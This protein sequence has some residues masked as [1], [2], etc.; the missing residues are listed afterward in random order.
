VS[1]GADIAKHVAYFLPD[2]FIAELPSLIGKTIPTQT[3]NTSHGWVVT[4]E[5]VMLS[6]EETKMREEKALKALARHDV[7]RRKK[8]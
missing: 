5:T 6:R 2:A 7:K 4:T 1:L 8:K 3:T